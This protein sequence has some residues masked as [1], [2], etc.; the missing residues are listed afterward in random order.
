MVLFSADRE[1]AHIRPEKAE[2]PHPLSYIPSFLIRSPPI[3]PQA[4]FLPPFCN[5]PI[6]TPL[7]VFNQ[8]LGLH[9]LPP[10]VPYSSHPPPCHIPPLW[11]SP[12]PPPPLR[13]SWPPKRSWPPTSF[14]RPKHATLAPLKLAHSANMPF[15]PPDSFGSMSWVKLAPHHLF[16]ARTSHLG[17]GRF[18]LGGRGGGVHPESA[19]RY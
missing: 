19:S 6:A 4:I 3:A 5:P 2:I 18:P 16:M 1:C 12:H 10:L 11:P 7:P 8:F 13:G 9:I 14:S 15:S 17:R